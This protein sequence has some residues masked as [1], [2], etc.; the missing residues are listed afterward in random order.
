MKKYFRYLAAAV[1]AAT[2]FAAVSC[3]DDSEP[4]PI[5]EF[6]APLQQQAIMPGDS[7][8]FTI[9]PN[10]DWVVSIP[11]EARAWFY[12]DDNGTKVSSL[13]GA[14]VLEGGQP[15]TVKVGT[16]NGEPFDEEPTVDVTM[17]MG[18]PAESRTIASF[19]IRQM[20]RDLK[21][22]PALVEE[23]EYV[24]NEEEGST[25]QYRYDETDAKKEGPV[26]LEKHGAFYGAR[27]LVESNVSWTL[28]VPEW[29]DVRVNAEPAT[30]G[31][32]GRSEVELR[33]NYAKMPLEGAKDL[34]CQ[35]SAQRADDTF[36]TLAKIA[37]SLEDLTG[38]LECEGLPKEALFSPAGNY[39]VSA[40][41][42][43]A[44]I[45]ASINAPDGVQIIALSKIQYG[46]EEWMMEPW[47]KAEIEPW[48]GED[49]IQT[50]SVA[51]KVAP[52]VA[53]GEQRQADL[54]VLPA[55]LA[56]KVKQPEDLL[57]EDWTA[58]REE[59]QKYLVTTVAQETSD[60]F[61]NA[62]NSLAMKEMGVK[63]EL[64]TSMFDS[65]LHQW[66]DWMHNDYDFYY[67]LT[68]T[69]AYSADGGTLDVVPVSWGPSDYA[70]Y[71]IYGYNA[72][73]AGEDLGADN[74]WI[75][76]Q[77]NRNAAT[78]AVESFTVQ[79][80]FDEE[81]VN[82]YGDYSMKYAVVV[83]YD[84]N[85]GA[86]ATLECEYDENGSIGGGG[87]VGAVSFAYPE[88]APMEGS[89]LEM[90]A[91]GDAD[92]DKYAAAY[93]DFTPT[94][95][96]VTFR[97]PN[98]TMSSLRGLP[99]YGQWCDVI[100]G[101][102]WLS[103]PEPSEEITFAGAMSSEKSASGA[104]IFYAGGA[105][106]DGAGKVVDPKGPAVILVVKLVVE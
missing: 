23:G 88:Y 69:N 72:G 86:I 77:E 49:K 64:G 59:Y 89:K 38:L 36:E 5:P 52:Q 85:G 91:A 26:A 66:N 21:F 100:D 60:Y 4:A 99:D 80:N 98:P 3:S 13:R 7:Y 2:S 75:K 55:T 63:F 83:F 25:L 33:A 43:G 35:F 1:L 95:Y 57:T 28:S 34:E 94:V 53:G 106:I 105:G 20:A 92:Y 29:V 9:K 37:V 39:L 76:L 45:N 14:A 101:A 19:V 79:M 70:S 104:Y 30:S 81:Y 78:N 16:E 103:R 102:D 12:L 51:I 96:R 87:E 84:E 67:K 62:H 97:T 44:A 11:D 40:S 50:R 46:Y 31:T 42:L 15:I 65:V 48:S 18:D 73:S 58:V 93:A 54:F 68:Y 82:T 74:K 90:L 6:P 47:V 61:F 56:E 71:K 24:F 27:L 17:T 41:S 22:Y 32:A 10:M 8:S